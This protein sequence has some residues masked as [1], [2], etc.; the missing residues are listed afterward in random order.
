MKLSPE[1]YLM[2]QGKEFHMNRALAFVLLTFSAVAIAQTPQIRS[3]ATVYIEPMDGYETYLA[4]A[5]I[6][7]HVPLVVVTDKSKAD[8]NITSNVSHKDMGQPAVVNN[9]NTNVINSNARSENPL[10]TM[11]RRS[12]D[13]QDQARAEQRALGETSV[14]IAVVDSRSSQVV[15]ADAAATTGTD[16]LQKTAAICAK[17]LLAF[18]EK[19]KN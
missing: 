11:A 12:R 19:K 2:P 7:K 16:Q 17:D 8:Y 3:G 10:D 15:F 18:I 14:S 5:M 9:S 6:K 13:R 1:V 4:A